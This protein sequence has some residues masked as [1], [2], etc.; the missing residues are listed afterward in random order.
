MCRDQKWFS[1]SLLPS[2]RGRKRKSSSDNREDTNSNN[3]SC[4]KYRHKKSDEMR[5]SIIK[6]LRSLIKAEKID[7]EK[8]LHEHSV[9]LSLKDFLNFEI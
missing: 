7:L 3:F 4:R 6:R 5:S 2:R 1:K 8:I 9:K